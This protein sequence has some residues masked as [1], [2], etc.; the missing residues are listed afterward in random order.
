MSGAPQLCFPAS[1]WSEDFQK[2][3]LISSDRVIIRSSRT[4]LTIAVGV[5]GLWG[6]GKTDMGL[7]GSVIA[8]GSEPIVTGA[9]DGTMR[10]LSGMRQ[11]PAEQIWVS[12]ASLEHALAFR[13]CG[14][15]KMEQQDCPPT[16][17]SH[18]RA[19]FEAGC[20]TICGKA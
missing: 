3:R 12:G 7:Q 18:R 15:S 19:A 8:S 2:Q 13:R 20:R 1:Q 11:G 17:S 6:D 14:A 16:H 10:S 9:V 5:A 4:G